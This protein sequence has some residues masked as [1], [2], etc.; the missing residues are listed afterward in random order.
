MY[1]LL[2]CN[3]A[4]DSWCSWF[5]VC[6]HYS[7]IMM[8]ST[9]I[10]PVCSM[11]MFSTKIT[12]W[13]FHD[14]VLDTKPPV[15][16]YYSTVTMST[17]NDPLYVIITLPRWCPRHKSHPPVC[18][19]YS[20]V[21]MPISCMWLLLSM[22]IPLTQT[23]HYVLINF[24]DHADDANVYVYHSHVNLSTMQM[25][26][27]TYYLL[28]Q[29]DAL[30]TNDPMYTIITTPQS[31][32]RYKQSLYMIALI[33]SPCPWMQMVLSIITLPWP[34]PRHKWARLEMPYQHWHISRRRNTQWQQ[35]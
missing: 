33:H 13:M 20:P 26:S 8:S 35:E 32:P 24:R 14:D 22:I 18:T 6:Y 3:H 15:W 9:Q 4:H 30:D 16:T 12:P 1:V 21:T 27:R 23:N 17:T 34:N 31:C 28:F 11:M 7:P 19:C 25:T 2:S 5:H 10:T 29:D